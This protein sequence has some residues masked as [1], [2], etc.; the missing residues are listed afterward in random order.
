[1]YDVKKKSTL[2]VMVKT[3]QKSICI[4]C[5][6]KGYFLNGIHNLGVEISLKGRRGIYFRK[7]SEI[8]RFL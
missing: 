2:L 6:G 1:M 5:E 8:G 7:M 4:L 3:K